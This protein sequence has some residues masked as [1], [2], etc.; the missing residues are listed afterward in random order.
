MSTASL[1]SRAKG[2]KTPPATLPVESNPGAG[3]PVGF[4]GSGIVAAA[5][6]YQ[7]TPYV[8]FISTKGKTFA[9]VAR[10]ISDLQEG[11]PVLLQGENVYPIKL[12]PFR[13]YLIS[14][15]Q[16][17]S[18]VDNL[19]QITRTILDADRAREDK[20]SKWV[21]HVETVLLVKLSHGALVPA[22]CTFKSTKTNAIH[23]AIAE[24]N[25]AADAES[26]AAKS[27]EHK[28][29]LAVPHPWARVL[30]TVT[31]KRG[32]SKSSGFSFVAAGGFVTP[33]GL[34]DWQ[35][36]ASAFQDP[37][38]RQLCEAVNQRHNERV[39]EIKGHLAGV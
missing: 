31:L 19:G 25:A 39:A 6:L 7:R 23:A 32:T 21:E 16:H 28:A 18:Q 37:A 22:R 17:F 2:N 35:S 15:F 14:A 11:D 27:P 8:L 34:A 4:S 30:T 38:F 36:L 9:E 3:L 12:N 33:T 20:A 26:W 24:V 1:A 10:H 13:F 5:P 29:S